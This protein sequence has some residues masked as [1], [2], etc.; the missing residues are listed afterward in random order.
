MGTAECNISYWNAHTLTSPKW[1]Y[2]LH[3]YGTQNNILS[4]VESRTTPHTLSQITQTHNLITNT[5]N[6]ILTAY[7]KHFICTDVLLDSPYAL[8]ISFS[9]CNYSFIHTAVHLANEPQARPPQL[10]AIDKIVASSD[11]PFVVGGDFNDTPTDLDTSSPRFH[12]TYNYMAT[13]LKWGID[14]WRSTHP[15]TFIPSHYNSHAQT[16]S[17]NYTYNRLDRIY[18][19]GL[20]FYN[21]HITRTPHLSD[22]ALV[23]V[24]ITITPPPP[25]KLW[26]PRPKRVLHVQLDGSHTFSKYLPKPSPLTFLFHLKST[27]KHL[28]NTSHKNTSQKQHTT[29]Q[30]EMLISGFNNTFPH[31]SLPSPPTISSINK[32]INT[33]LLEH[34]ITTNTISPSVRESI[35]LIDNITN[36]HRTLSSLHTPLGTL[37]TDRLALHLIDET[38]TIFNTQQTQTYNPNITS[39]TPFTIR[40]PTPYDLLNISPEIVDLAICKAARK[41]TRGPD[42]IVAS[43][44]IGHTQHII[45]IIKKYATTPPPTHWFDTLLIYIP[46][47]GG[48]K[49][50]TFSQLRPISLENTIIRIISNIINIV[51]TPLVP[52]FGGEHQYGFTPGRSAHIP[53]HY[54]NTLVRQGYGA[55]FLDFSRAFTNTPTTPLTHILKNI[56]LPPSLTTWISYLF[57]PHRAHLLI[58]GRVFK[59]PCQI[60][61]G[62]R[63]GN[64]LSPPLF[65]LY[66]SYFIGE[67]R[68]RFPDVICLF[69]ADDGALLIPPHLITPTFINTLITSIIS[70]S[71]TIHIPLN[72]NKTQTINLQMQTTFANV[73]TFRYLGIQIPFSNLINNPLSLKLNKVKNLVHTIHKFNPSPIHNAYIFNTYILSKL[74][75]TLS[76]THISKEHASEIEWLIRHMVGT[77]SSHKFYCGRPIHSLFY[78]IGVGGLGL[79]NPL[80]HSTCCKLV[81]WRAR[82]GKV[83]TPPHLLALSPLPHFPDDPTQDQLACSRD[84]HG[85]IH[86]HILYKVLLPTPSLSPTANLWHSHYYPFFCL[87]PP[88]TLV[89]LWQFFFEITKTPEHLFKHFPITP[90]SPCPLCKGF[91]L[92]GPTHALKCPKFCHTGSLLSHTQTQPHSLMDVFR[93][94]LTHQ[95][96]L[97]TLLK[98][99]RAI[100]NVRQYPPRH[101]KTNKGSPTHKQHTP[102]RTKQTSAPPPKPPTK[103]SLPPPLPPPLQ[104]YH[105]ERH[106]NPAA[107]AVILRPS[108]SMLD[109][110]KERF[111]PANR[112]RRN[113][114]E[115]KGWPP[116][117]PPTRN[118]IRA[119]SPPFLTPPR[120][121]P[122]PKPQSITTKPQTLIT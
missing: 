86:S 106:H 52:H 37:H 41:Q 43:D 118:K 83:H 64:T 66:L 99:C 8:I 82:E 53:I 114:I 85:T 57:R 113:E 78:P 105:E 7:S 49:P 75:Y 20:P 63:Q 62:L 87:L 46:K 96:P 119:R 23:S 93:L 28:T 102:T 10:D 67:I 104:L 1:D 6:T 92:W 73:D 33:A 77:T 108:R 2:L 30:L 61:A 4:I 12:H 47:P 54:A 9:Y 122:P 117:P 39:Y 27:I 5:Q 25:S 120:T 95:I 45:N 3:S 29:T 13:Y 38:H 55:I 32:T 72:I 115:L 56:N 42:G 24:T 50:P 107:T 121:P 110:L 116:P 21:T 15:G 65:S 18:L 51:I 17:A 36:T 81:W 14:T 89:I 11:L 59:T 79:R 34:N 74:T 112:Y 90:I 84:I 60:G 19:K 68:K 48:D 44:Y 88:H 98:W 35:K 58:G 97:T 40:D 103:P 22:H 111:S 70:L 109:I 69:F 26:Y 80:L 100:T 16:T 31:Y 71:H 91:S 101:K 94:T 76:H